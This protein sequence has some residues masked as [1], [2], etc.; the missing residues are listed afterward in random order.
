MD[1][2]SSIYIDRHRDNFTTYFAQTIRIPES[3]VVIKAT[4]AQ[5]Y[6]SYDY[7]Q[8]DFS[9]DS[10]MLEKEELEEFG[11]SRMNIC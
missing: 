1:S 11:Y 3:D 2:N 7:P 4:G 10:V 5:W 6:W 9:F 8:H